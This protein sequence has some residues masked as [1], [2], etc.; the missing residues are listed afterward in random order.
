M[1]QTFFK[2]TEGNT[3]RKKKSS[4]RVAPFGSRKNSNDDLKN[5]MDASGKFGTSLD[6]SNIPL[7]DRNHPKRQGKQK[8]S[9]T[10]R[11]NF[12]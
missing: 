9:V 8:L 6:L 3:L 4:A 12:E 7:T 11:S 10:A 1:D 2:K 5:S